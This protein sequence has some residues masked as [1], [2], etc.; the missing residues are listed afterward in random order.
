MS[1]RPKCSSKAGKQW[2]R[3]VGGLVQ[4]NV[5]EGDFDAQ[6]SSSSG[7]SDLSG[8]GVRSLGAGQ[9]IDFAS[10]LGVQSDCVEGATALKCQSNS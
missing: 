8:A 1:P 6:R 2:Y 5:Q 7:A 4:S 9:R 3:L 10:D